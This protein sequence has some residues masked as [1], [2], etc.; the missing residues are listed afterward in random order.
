MRGWEG[1]SKRH[2]K[3]HR[4]DVPETFAASASACL[5]GSLAYAVVCPDACEPD[6]ELV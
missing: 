6:S 2:L 3:D 1:T 4:T 5:A